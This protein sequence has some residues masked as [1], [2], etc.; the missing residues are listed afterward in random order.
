MAD[1]I[2]APAPSANNVTVFLSLISRYLLIAYAPRTSILLYLSSAR[3]NLDATSRAVTKPEQAELRSNV[4]ALRAPSLSCTTEAV[5]GDI[6]SGVSVEIIIRS[7]SSALSPPFSSA[8]LAASTHR[9][10]VDSSGEHHLRSL[11]VRFSLSQVST[12]S[13]SSSLKY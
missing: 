1:K 6:N 13:P 4:P 7:S 5:E 11:I 12:S 2:T 3:M 9:S 10:A 8:F